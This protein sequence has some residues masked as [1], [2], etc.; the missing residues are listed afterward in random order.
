MTTLLEPLQPDTEHLKELGRTG[1]QPSKNLETFAK[2]D[3]LSLVEMVS[4]EFTSLC[5]VTS[6]P[7]YQTV[8][9]KFTPNKKCIESK[10]LK[11]YLM[12][13]RN[14]GVFCEAL[15]CQIARDV[16]VMVDPFVVE[17]TVEQKARGGVAINAVATLVRGEE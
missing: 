15:A 4:D 10:S 13:Y 12:S 5:P 6:Q 16:M 2:P 9:I 17:V 3:G 7:D 1:S 11:L 8:T 14:E